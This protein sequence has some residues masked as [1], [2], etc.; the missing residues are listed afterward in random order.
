MLAHV[1]RF[2]VEMN[3]WLLALQQPLALIYKEYCFLCLS[4]VMLTLVTNASIEESS[5]DQIFL[6]LKIFS[7]SFS[8]RSLGVVRKHSYSGESETLYLFYLFP[9]IMPMN[10]LMFGMFRMRYMLVSLS[11]HT[12]RLSVWSDFVL[13]WLWLSAL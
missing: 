4:G 10:K 13:K 11:N 1:L 8:R 6:A 9:A 5:N 3:F 12:F 7:I 2:S